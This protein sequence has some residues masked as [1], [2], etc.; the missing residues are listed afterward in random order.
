MFIFNNYVYLYL[1]TFIFFST[2]QFETQC[3]YICINYICNN[4]FNIEYLVNNSDTEAE[5][6]ENPK[7]IA[8][9]RN[10]TNLMCF[11]GTV[12]FLFSPQWYKCFNLRS[13]VYTFLWNCKGLIYM[14]TSKKVSLLARDIRW[15][16]LSHRFT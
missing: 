11:C 15:I 10:H 13:T 14:Y 9:Y 3:I 5:G 12:I 8:I 6:G 16:S 4:D 7:S 1:L 2:V